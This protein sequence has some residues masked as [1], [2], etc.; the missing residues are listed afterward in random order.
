MPYRKHRGFRRKIDHAKAARKKQIAHDVN[1]IDY[2]FDGQYIKG[3]IHC[4][5]PLC[6]AKTGKNG[7]KHSDMLKFMSIMEQMDESIAKQMNERSDYQEA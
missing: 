3:K 1:G 2:K 4:S 5:C 6:A 7:Y